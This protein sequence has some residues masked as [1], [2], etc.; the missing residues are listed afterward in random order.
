[1]EVLKGTKPKLLITE[2]DVDNRKFLKMFLSKFFVVNVCDSAESF[3]E[4]LQKDEYD[5]IM[6]DIA[7]RGE[8][9]GLQLTR[10]L[11]NNP[12]YAKIPVLCYTGYAFNQ[13]RIN[14]LDAG[15]DEY[16]SKPS[17]I[18][19]L[20]NTLFSLLKEKGKQVLNEQKFENISL[21]KI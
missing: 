2:G 4:L 3:Y 8:K 16:L 15:C 14:A 21:S 6:M 1:M 19:V 17:D 13:D 5:I 20:L 18:K 12:K 11:K 9:N 10:E 7:I